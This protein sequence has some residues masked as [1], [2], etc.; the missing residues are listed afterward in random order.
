MR[1]ALSISQETMRTCTAVTSYL[2]EGVLLPKRQIPSALG[3]FSCHD[4]FY[5][6]SCI[7]PLPWPHST[8]SLPHTLPKSFSTRGGELL[9]VSFQ[10]AAPGLRGLGNRID[11][12][13][14]EL[15]N[16]KEQAA[17]GCLKKYLTS[18]RRHIENTRQ[19]ICVL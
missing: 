19:V 4:I 5:S 13:G 18:P 16:R 11:K 7:S 14:S 12:L 1:M 17:H 10:D 9:C 8:L 2:R 15:T 3:L 6:L